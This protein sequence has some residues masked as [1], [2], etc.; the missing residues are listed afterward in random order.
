MRTGELNTLGL[1]GYCFFS[2]G[3]GNFVREEGSVPHYMP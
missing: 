3:G 1:G 2:W